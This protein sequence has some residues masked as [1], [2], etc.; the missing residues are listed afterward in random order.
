MQ[1]THVIYKPGETSIQSACY[2]DDTGV[3]RSSCT[4][5]RISTSPSGITYGPDLI[6][7][8]HLAKLNAGLG[9]AEPKFQLMEFDAAMPLIHQAQD[10][11]YVTSWQPITEDQWNQWLGCLPPCRWEIVNGVELFYISEAYTSTIHTHCARV[12]EH[13]F[14]RRCRTSTPYPVLAAEIRALI[15]AA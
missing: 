12:G 14:A 4:G 1:Y 5:A 15:P 10:A 2:P 9:D 11:C 3:L 8:D 7:A 6:A 13:Y